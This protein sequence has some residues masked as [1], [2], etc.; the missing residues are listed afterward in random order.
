MRFP[1]LLSLPLALV[2]AAPTLAQADAEAEFRVARRL[3][4][5]GSPQAADALDRVFR[6]DPDGPLADDALLER[7]LLVGMA[8]WMRVISKGAFGRALKVEFRP[9]DDGRCDTGACELGS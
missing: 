4:A 9:I 1:T 5:E 8:G 2:L 6:L 3:V 7:A